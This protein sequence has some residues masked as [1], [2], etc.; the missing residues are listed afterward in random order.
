M[1]R[2]MGGALIRPLDNAGLR[3]LGG[4]IDWLGSQPEVD[5]LRIGVI[6]FCMG[7]GFAL[8]LACVNDHLKASAVFYGGNPRPLSA[9]AKACP[10]VGSYPAKDPFTRGGA[11]KLERALTQYGVPHDI[12]IYPNAQH[13]FFNDRLPTYNA[14]AA[15]DAWQRTLAFFHTHLD[16]VT[17]TQGEDRG[18]SQE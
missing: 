8:A 2:V 10:I 1:L 14:E 9:V 7:G 11:S 3:D 18:P 16:V 15:R 4:Q 13:S 17:D 6:G 12:K 5:T